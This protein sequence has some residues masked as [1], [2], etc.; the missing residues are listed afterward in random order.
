MKNLA[1]L[2]DGWLWQTMSSDAFDLRAA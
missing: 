2:P 1:R